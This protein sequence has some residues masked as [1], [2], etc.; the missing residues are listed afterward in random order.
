MGAL[1]IEG[2]QYLSN[3]KIFADAFNYLVYDGEEVIKPERLTELDTTG[4]TVPYGDNARVP[5]QKYRDLL[6]LWNAMTDNEAIY[7][8]LGAELQGKIHYGMPVKDALYDANRAVNLGLE[9][10]EESGGIDMCKAMEKKQTKDEINGAIK[11]LRTTG[12]SDN[13]IVTKI[14]E[15]FHVKKEYV[16]SLL[17]PQAV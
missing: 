14:V 11:F 9:Y 12:A 8:I 7:V 6:K 13:D 1:D 4:I 2:K 17:T 5:E 3:N 15:T 16:L 10:E